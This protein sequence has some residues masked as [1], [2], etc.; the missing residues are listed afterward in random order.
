MV[1]RVVSVVFFG[2]SICLAV[3]LANPAAAEVLIT[4]C[5][6]VATERARLAADLD[7]SSHVGSAVVLQRTT[8]YLDGHKII[9]SGRV[10]SVPYSGVAV[11]CV[12]PD[13]SYADGLRPTRCTVVGP[14]EISGADDGIRSQFPRVRGATITGNQATG[15]GA[16][17]RLRLT[18]TIV[19]NNGTA[20]VVV[21]G[22]GRSL[23][24]GSTLR[25]N[26][27]PG[28]IYNSCCKT[29]VGLTIDD[30]E[31]TLNAGHGVLNATSQ[32]LTIRGSTVSANALDPGSPYCATAPWG[33]EIGCADITSYGPV[34][35][36]QTVCGTSFEP[37]TGETLGICAND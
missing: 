14:G 19:S 26:D 29:T 22:R 25:E 10:E 33:G 5:G 28:V 30:S 15:V 36:A 32:P 6:Q 37:L 7:C 1:A 13:T 31:I 8:L 3:T 34:S 23:I 17:G 24:S 11:A 27:G 35:V 21:V 16:T 9:G 4:T 2:L 20:G 12:T 18:D